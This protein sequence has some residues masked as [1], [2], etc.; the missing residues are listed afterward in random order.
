MKKIVALVLVFA[1]CLSIVACA[2]KTETPAAAAPTAELRF[3]TGGESGTYYA[4]GSVIAQHITNNTNVKAIALVGAGS[5]GNVTQLRDGEA[6]LAFCQSDVMA[7]AYEGT[8]LFA[9]Y[10]KVTNFSTLC[11]LYTEQVQIVTTNPDIKTVDD[12][13]GKSVSIGAAGSGVYFNAIDVLAAYGMTLDDI[14]PT[15]QSF[16]DTT[17]SIKDGKIDAG[18]VVSGA[19]TTSIVSLAADNKNTHLVSL[20]E[21]HIAALIASSPYYAKCV[22]KA[23]TYSTLAEDVYTVGVGAVVLV[24]DTVSEDAAYAVVADIF[25][26]AANLTESHAKYGEV[27]LEYGSSITS[28]PYHKGAA[29]YFAEKGITV[30]TK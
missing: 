21:E 18:F 3:V 5:Q 2:K 28:V 7:Y 14:T 25:N 30:P 6:E 24:A 1:L 9:D 27:S 17:E 13:R 16:G 22:I 29:K 26:N 11:A 12:L 4:F 10:G 19:P 15:Y 20:D 23:G 8:N